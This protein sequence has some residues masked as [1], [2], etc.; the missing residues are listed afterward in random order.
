VGT[1]KIVRDPRHTGQM[2]AG[3]NQCDVVHVFDFD[4]GALAEIAT[5]RSEHL[6]ENVFR[7]S[8]ALDDAK[9]D[10]AR[11]VLNH[12]KALNRV[13]EFLQEVREEGAGNVVA[14]RALNDRLDP[15][16]DGT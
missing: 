13:V 1:L 3:A 9:Q 8:S 12:L 11:L 16:L 6:L 14:V 5:K 2:L 4:F 15:T 7:K 10:R